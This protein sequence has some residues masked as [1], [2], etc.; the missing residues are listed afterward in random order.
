[1]PRIEMFI[2]LAQWFSTGGDSASPHTPEGCLAMSEVILIVT[3]GGGLEV[4]AADMQWAE[5]RMIRWITYFFIPS[6]P[7]PNTTKNYLAENINS[8][9]LKNPPLP[10]E[11]SNLHM[12]IYIFL[13]A[14]Y[15]KILFCSFETAKVKPLYSYMSI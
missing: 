12:V 3:H 1:M 4:V 14:K 7:P 8:L 10:L 5:V 9:K 2:L 11:K 6:M 15:K 13:L